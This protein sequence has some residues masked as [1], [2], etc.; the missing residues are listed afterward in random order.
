[1]IIGSWFMAV[2]SMR[3]YKFERAWLAV[4]VCMMSSLNCNFGVRQSVL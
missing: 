4:S 2:S 3:L 1:M